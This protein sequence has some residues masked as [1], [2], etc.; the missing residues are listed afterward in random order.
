MNEAALELTDC[1]FSKVL[2]Q[3]MEVTRC[4]IKIRNL[5]KEYSTTSEILQS[6]TVDHFG[7]MGSSTYIMGS[8]Y[9]GTTLDTMGSDQ[10]TVAVLKPTEV[11]TNLQNYHRTSL[12]LIQDDFTPPG[13]CKLQLVLNGISVTK[14]YC[15]EH[16]TLLSAI[17]IM[18]E[19]FKIETDVYDRLLIGHLLSDRIE[20]SFIREFHGPAMQRIGVKGKNN[21]MDVDM[22]PAFCCLCLPT[23]AMQWFT[24]KRLYDWPP[25]EVIE[26]CRQL[27][28]FVVP[29]G[30]PNSPEKDKEWR[31]S[32]SLQERMLVTLFNSSQLKCF[33]VLKVLKN[34]VIN[35]KLQGKILTSYHCKTCMLY[36]VETTPNDLWVPDNLLKCITACLK[37]LREWAND[38]YCPN[39][40]IPEENMF[41]KLESKDLEGL[42]NT[43]K[44]LVTGNICSVLFG[45]KTD[46]IGGN[47]RFWRKSACS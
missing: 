5:C 12:L 25:Q 7:R 20:V 3:V 35:Q 34:E 37:K 14:L 46:G 47:L 43:L 29:V 36:M 13:Y 31:I 1:A 30:H 8:R 33:V 28:F 42:S 22:V 6:I 26:E 9:E 19:A 38:K 44:T 4:S 18:F 16:P 39:Y 15:N 27:G 24:R 40:F 10:D 32:L 41:D 45:L 21:V 11:V 2:Y 17:Y 23:R